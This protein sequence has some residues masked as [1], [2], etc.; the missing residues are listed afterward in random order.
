MSDFKGYGP[1]HEHFL[2][3]RIADAIAGADTLELAVEYVMDILNTERLVSY[4]KRDRVALQTR[5]GRAFVV[6]VEH[7]DATHREIASRLGIQES[8]AYK[9]ITKLLEDGMIQRQKRKAGYTYTPCYDSVWKHPDVWRFALAILRM[10][11]EQPDPSSD[12]H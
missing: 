9:V 3:K 1:D 4:S 5:A 10:S 6:V 11:K 2:K 7:P 12:I 8:G